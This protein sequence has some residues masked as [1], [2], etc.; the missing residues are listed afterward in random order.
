MSRILLIEDDPALCR[1]LRLALEKSG[2]A[3]T[4]APNGRKGLPAFLQHPPQL[5]ITDIF[6]PEVD[7]IETIRAFRKLRPEV[8]IIAISGGGRLGSPADYLRM[9]RMIGANQILDRPLE[10]DALRAAA[11]QLLGP[12]DAPREL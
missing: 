6:M 11:A 10:I 8:P 7:G 2:H 3:V 1:A 4:E 9:A 12:A 5:V